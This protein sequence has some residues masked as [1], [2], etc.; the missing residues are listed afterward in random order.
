[1]I[2]AYFVVALN[3]K[4]TSMGTRHETKQLSPIP[5]S[6]AGSRRSL[7]VNGRRRQ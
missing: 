6:R 3:R 5:E 1:M 2:K 7:L 4:R